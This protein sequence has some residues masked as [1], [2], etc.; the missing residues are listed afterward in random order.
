MTTKLCKRN[1]AS[2]GG[3]RR[4]SCW[5]ACITKAYQVHSYASG[6]GP[7]GCRLDITNIADLV[8]CC[9]GACDLL[10]TDSIDSKCVHYGG[11]IDSVSCVKTSCKGSAIVL[12]SAYIL[13][14]WRNQ[15]TMT[16]K[17][18]GYLRITPH[19][20]SMQGSTSTVHASL[21]PGAA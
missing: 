5:L 9:A 19:L 21:L 16:C 20:Q 10:L 18:F 17:D 1:D 4:M 2:F 3:C 14:L 7:I 15:S 12:H 11:T 13:P 8:W 6:V